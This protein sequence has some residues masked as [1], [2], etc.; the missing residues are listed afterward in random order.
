MQTC[1]LAAVTLMIACGCGR[2]FVGDTTSDAAVTAIDGLS[3]GPGNWC[4][5]AAATVYVHA[6]LGSDTNNGSCATPFK[7]ISKA[8]ATT[9]GNVALN[10][11][12]VGG[13]TSGAPFVYGANETGEVF[14]LNLATKLQLIGDG[15]DRV[16]VNGGGAV[17]GQDDQVIVVANEVTLQGINVT[18][19]KSGIYV[20]SGTLTTKQTSITNCTKVGIAVYKAAGLA[21]ETTIIAGNESGLWSESQQLT[22]TNSEVRDQRGSGVVI[23][24]DGLITSQGT[25]Y[26]NNGFSGIQLIRDGKAKST[27]DIF[28]NNVNGISMNDRDNLSTG[29]EVTGSEFINNGTGINVG[30]AFNVVLRNCRVLGNRGDG[31]YIDNSASSASVFDLGT[32]SQPGGNTLQSAV[33]GN[34]G[35]G[36]CNRSQY[37]VTAAGNTFRGCPGPVTSSPTC[38]GG[39]N[40]SGNVVASCL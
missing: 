37:S 23:L 15:K 21:S 1:R 39:V 36:V 7:S 16:S 14:P 20:A 9:N 8:V 33:G 6:L 19:S 34:A 40:V 4:Q 12:R 10:I 32:A 2:K 26:A 3:D 5:P 29:A 18:G 35:A 24:A 13:S 28:D 11:I 25:R 22:L 30:F 17:A 27:L 31:I 38:S